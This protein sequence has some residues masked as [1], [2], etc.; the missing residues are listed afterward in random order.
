MFLHQAQY[1]DIKA[2][3]QPGDLF[4]FAGT[5][6]VSELIQ[7][8]THSVV[9]HVGNVFD[10]DGRMIQATTLNG[11][12]GVA[13]SHTTDELIRY[14]GRVWI[15]RLAA[16]IRSRFNAAAYEDAC[17]AQANRPYNYQGI[18]NF[19]WR[20]VFPWAKDR[21]RHGMFCSQR[22]ADAWMSAGVLPRTKEASEYSP[23]D[24]VGLSIY[25]RDYFQ[26][27]G[28]PMELAIH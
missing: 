15:L 24:I 7:E 5:G 27:I 12:D 10:Q 19:A 9:S 22:T 25:D 17:L 28:E 11:H 18:L 2:L 26:V 3:L 20:R 21:G 8:F 13:I 1:S 4:A 23:A 14:P 16:D 6:T